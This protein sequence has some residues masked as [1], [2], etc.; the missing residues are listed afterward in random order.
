MYGSYNDSIL[1][2]IRSGQAVLVDSDHSI[3]VGIQLEPAY[4]H[5]PG[6]IIV[7]VESEGDHAILCGDV[8][9][10]PLQL[11]KPMWSSNFC[12]DPELSRQTRLN[13]LNRCAG[14]KISLL[15]AHFHSPEYG[16]IERDKET[17]Q[18]IK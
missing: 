15:P 9:H 11:L 2:V 16:Y 5:T 14:A 13:L 18:L 1:P 12:H 10:H 6:N 8:I 7:N 3:D 4:G 17:F